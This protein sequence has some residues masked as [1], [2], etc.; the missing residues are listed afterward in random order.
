MKMDTRKGQTMN[1]QASSVEEI[2]LEGEL[3]RESIDDLYKAVTAN[4]NMT[5]GGSSTKALDTIYDLLV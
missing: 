3:V 1:S 5:A 2:K 4:G